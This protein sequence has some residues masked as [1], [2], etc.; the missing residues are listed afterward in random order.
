MPIPLILQQLLIPVALLGWMILRPIPGRGRFLIQATGVG[1]A[2]L[3]IAKVGMWIMPPWWVPWTFA[4]T[5]ALASIWRLRHM[6]SK[7]PAEARATW[8]TR[9]AV[10]FSLVLAL[11][12]GWGT[13]SA[14]AARG[15]PAADVID[16]P[17]PLGPGS[18][19]VAHGGRRTIVNIHLKTLDSEVERFKAWRGQSY[20]LD[21]V[22]IDRL[23]LRADGVR[24]VDPS[25]YV[26]FGAPVF[27][28]CNGEV[29][30]A[31]NG[32]PDLPVPRMDSEHLLG[33]HVFLQCDGIVLV[34][35]HLREGSVLVEEGERVTPGQRLGEVGN[36]GNTSEPH[37]HLHAQRPG[38]PG[39][40][41]SGEPVGVRVDG[42]WLVR[43]DRIKGRPW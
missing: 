6:R 1:V 14:L 18:Y 33:N 2:L 4:A 17:N 16:L 7:V 19:L 38:Q 26:I 28:P 40:P 37:L 20:A 41:V 29:A 43:N 32:R 23:G 22:G 9:T 27:A 25:R 31:E 8:E 35:A 10:A 21:L 12:G 5:W 3:A 39:S 24:P 42:R 34:F 30:E 15:A 13:G 36:S 11:V